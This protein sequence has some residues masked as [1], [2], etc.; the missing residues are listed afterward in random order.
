MSTLAVRVL[1]LAL[2]P[3]AGC[4]SPSGD[5]REEQV[6]SALKMR[7]QALAL[8]IAHKPELEQALSASDGYVVFSTFSL[9][10][11]ILSFASG[12]GVFVNT[13]AG[14]TTHMRW[15]RLTI[16]PGIAIKGLYSLGIFHDQQALE[17]FEDG[18]WA[19]IGQ[20]EAS[21]VFG[22]FGGCA[23]SSWIYNRDLET[24]YLTHTGV[25]LE[26]ELIGLGL[27]SRD[28][29]LSPEPSR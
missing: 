4:M 23:A 19:A 16:G 13:K 5:T 3:L 14:R 22:D 21:F 2:L 8:M 15:T 17:A 7:D 10:P 29:D 11:G 20:A 28:S 9:H 27:V 18:G 24:H 6:A 25:A 26:L 1:I 12:Y